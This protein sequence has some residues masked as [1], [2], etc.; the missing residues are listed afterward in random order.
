MCEH[1]NCTMHLD[2][3]KCDDCGLEVSEYQE[4]RKEIED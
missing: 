1:I 3:E 4:A 2:H